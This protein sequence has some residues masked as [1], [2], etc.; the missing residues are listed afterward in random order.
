MEVELI[1]FLRGAYALAFS[2]AGPAV[3][4][5]GFSADRSAEKLLFFTLGTFMAGAGF[6]LI[7]SRVTEPF[8][9]WSK[10]VGFFFVLGVV[11]V[12]SA[13]AGHYLYSVVR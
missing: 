6:V 5:A 11:V 4:M 1:G 12:F 3:L 8:G 13:T 9:I 10:M 2:V 7:R